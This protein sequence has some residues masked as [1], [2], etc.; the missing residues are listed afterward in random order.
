MVADCPRHPRTPLGQYRAALKYSGYARV[1]AGEQEVPAL[2][3]GR[4]ALQYT[5]VCNGLSV[6]VLPKECVRSAILRA[7]T[8]TTVGRA[9]VLKIGGEMLCQLQGDRLEGK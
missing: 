1:L 2:S 3:S 7:C 9:R 5:V 6:R 8:P 4:L